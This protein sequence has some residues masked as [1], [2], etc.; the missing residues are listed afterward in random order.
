MWRNRLT[1]VTSKLTWATWSMLNSKPLIEFVHQ[2][3][4][5]TGDTHGEFVCR[6]VGPIYLEPTFGYL[7]SEDGYLL[8]ESLLPNFSHPH[9]AWRVA[10][11]TPRAF[12]KAR[13]SDRQVQH[14]RCVIS[15][16]HLWEWNYYHFYLDV[17]G[18]LQLF[19]HIGID[20]ETPLVLGRYA[21]ELP[22]VQQVLAQGKLPARNWIIQD[23]GYIVADE[24]YFCRTRQ[25]YKDKMD[26][27]LD[28]MD[29]PNRPAADHKRIFLSRRQGTPR[30]V[31]NM[32]QIKPLLDAYDFQIIDTAG[33]SVTK[34]IDLFAKTGYLLAVHGA[35][36]TNLIFRRDAPMSVVEIHPTTYVSVDYRNM[37]HE[38]GY[39]FDRLV[40]LPDDNP[41]PQ[42]AN[43]YID[44][45]QLEQKIE[46]M[47]KPQR[48]SSPGSVVPNRLGN[49]L[50][51]AAHAR[52]TFA[53]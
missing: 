25:R 18:K 5:G 49:Q 12:T 40:C 2:R 7:I 26:Y 38:W 14:H 6:A 51:S 32:A 21:R 39:Q 36:M 50:S 11:P 8:E 43:L 45:I 41:N 16:R 10:L 42:H 34:Q 28:Y 1:K 52:A 20:P 48:K 4:D 44:P 47:L 37:C 17:L 19:D 15:L 35:G 31:L 23:D 9:P 13:R 30:S 33:L 46:Q 53:R 29:V 22:F 3:N 27:L 24:I